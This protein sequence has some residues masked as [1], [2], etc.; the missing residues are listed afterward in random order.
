MN[1]R[2]DGRDVAVAPGDTVLYAARRAGIDVPVLCYDPALPIEG[3]C[4]VCMVEDESTGKLVAACHTLLRNG[5]SLRTQSPRLDEIRR[6]LLSLMVSAHPPGAFTPRGESPFEQLLEQYAVDSGTLGSPS[7]TAPIDASHPYLRFDAGRCIV[8]RRCLHACESIQGQFVYGIAGR[9]PTTSLILGTGSAFAESA[10]VACGACVDHCPTGAVSDRDRLQELAGADSTRSTCGYCGVGCQINVLTRADRV[11][12]IEPSPLAAVNRGHLCAKGRYAHGYVTSPDRLTKPLLR[13]S[14]GFREIGWTEAN[15]WAAERFQE[16][17]ERH[18]ADAIAGLASSRSTNEA[19]YLLQKFM[20]VIIGTNNIDCCARVC[21][22]STALALK[23]VTGTGAASASYA[24]IERARII[25]VAGAN[26]TEAHPVVGARIKQA[27]LRGTPLIVIDPRR[28]ELAEYATVHLALRPGTNVPVFNALGR[29][30]LD[31]GRVNRGYVGGRTEGF[32]EYAAF[33]HG[34]EP[35]DVCE[36][37][38]IDER[39]LR[40]AA[41]LIGAHAPALFVHGLGLSE[42]TQ[43]TDSVMALANLGML[44]GSIGAPGAGMLPLRGQNN[45]QGAA[46]MGAAPDQLT[47]YRPISDAAARAGIAAIWGSAPPS[48]AGLTVTEMFEAAIAGRVRAMWIQG[49]DSAQSD[50]CQDRS[51]RALSKLDLLIVQDPFFN[52]T[53]RFAHLVLP[54]ATTLENDGT[55]TNGERRI[56]RVR[57]AVA[58]R[59]DAW[60]DWRITLDIANAMGA[61]WA[62]D[63]PSTVM[64]EIAKAAPHLF[65]GVAYSRL[66]GDGLQ[67]PCPAPGH[68]GTAA[69]HADGFIRGRGRFMCL[70]YL[71]SPEAPSGEFPLTLITGRVLQQYNVGTMTARTPNRELSPA[72]VLEVSAPD[73]ADAGLEDGQ[74]AHVRSKWGQIRV[75]AR[76]TERI[77]PGTA[78]LSFHYAESHTNRVTGPHVDPKSKCPE[79][80]ITAVSVSP[81]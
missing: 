58:P 12:A 52:E 22:S 46:D 55:Y 81:A 72:D 71:P 37:A 60:P 67:W 21:H 43:G 68:P 41:D 65:G 63:S 57:P 79:Y 33:V 9:G 18:G 7:A 20:R 80:K 15:R 36:L 54:A 59:G 25:V 28:I 32:D 66:D 38:Q 16:I 1:A 69:V 14:T 5:M 70:P 2:I 64:D 48:R 26:P 29:L 31:G 78:F 76:V 17:R 47:G 35:R 11:L 44:T 61:H 49:E 19:A 75:R 10:C 8:C 40:S 13:D 50:P 3:G 27:A 4:R 24:D 23:T 51:E 74:Y 73:A 39:A 77:R 53:A 30:L 45:V 6:G 34:F 62:Y 42:L 56:Q